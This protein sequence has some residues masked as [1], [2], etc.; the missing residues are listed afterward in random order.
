MNKVVCG[1][2]Q[3]NSL[4]FAGKSVAEVVSLCTSLLAV[5]EDDEIKINGLDPV[6]GQVIND[7][8][9]IEFK[10]SAGDKGAD[11]PTVSVHVQSGVNTVHI[12]VKDGSTIATVL[13][14]A[15][16][17]LGLSLAG[18]DSEIVK[19][20]QPAAKSD[21]V[22]NGDRIEFKKSAGDKGVCA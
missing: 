8:D 1:V 12:N 13:K 14:Q 6:Q 3:S 15:A 22:S 10:K 4:N 17:A 2:N 5:G 21:V 11:V 18:E 7:G 20:G 19:N 9:V 16:I